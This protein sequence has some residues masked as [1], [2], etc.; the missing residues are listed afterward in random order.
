[1][2]SSAKDDLV[3]R[4]AR[5]PP[6][7]LVELL[8]R[9]EW[10]TR[11][12]KYRVRGMSRILGSIADPHFL[13]LE[14]KGQLLGGVV[15]SRKSVTAAGKS[16]DAF[17]IAM[18][19]VERSAAGSGYGTYLAKRARLY[20]HALLEEPGLIYLYVESTSTASLNVHRAVGYTA[21]GRLE[22]R[23]F[24]RMYPKDDV[25]VG[26]PTRQE[27]AELSSRLEEQYAGHV[28]LDFDTSLRTGGYLVLRSGGEVAAGAQIRP[29]EWSLTRLR[30]I[31]GFLAMRVLPHLPVIRRGYSP[32]HARFLRIGNIFV[33][34][35]REAELE[36]LLE[37]LLA[38][39]GVHVAMIF[40]DPRSAVHNAFKAR[41]GFGAFGGL[42]AETMDVLADFKGLSQEEIARLRALPINVSPADPM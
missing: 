11:E 20:A 25:R 3:L 27:L 42:V 6:L 17:F 40:L 24:T 41:V 29:M 23:L 7:A 36:S 32:D 18:I 15:G 14:R 31:G 2:G 30:G 22:A 19:A 21:I 10:G 13:T 26:R 33:R 37:A 5:T 1:M 4:C 12:V 9:T 34:P 28:L 38:R 35:G 8:K 16:Y 39:C